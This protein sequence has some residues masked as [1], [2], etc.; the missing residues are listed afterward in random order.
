MGRVLVASLAMFS[1]SIIPT[2]MADTRPNCARDDSSCLPETPRLVQRTAK[3]IVE[4]RNSTKGAPRDKQFL[5]GL[6]RDL[7]DRKKTIDETERGVLQ[8]MA[9]MISDT[10]LPQLPTEKNCGPNRT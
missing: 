2:A 6:A 9:A 7:D 4:T 10:S 1:V 3:P 8:S 5:I